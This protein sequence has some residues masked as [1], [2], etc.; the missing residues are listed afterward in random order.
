MFSTK[1]LK[2]DIR[3]DWLGYTHNGKEIGLNLTK[4]WE[5]SKNEEHFVTI[6]SKVY[7]HELVHRELREL[8][9][10]LTPYQEEYIISKMLSNGLSTTQKKVYK[11]IYSNYI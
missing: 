4:M 9:P 2:N 11:L 3:N 10:T 5:Q 7:E 1:I 6:F 8:R